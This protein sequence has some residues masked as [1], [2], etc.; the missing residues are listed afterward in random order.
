[1]V[2]T[3]SSANSSNNLFSNFSK[4]PGVKPAQIS[5]AKTQ[6]PE[7]DEF[8]SSSE[9][10]SKNVQTVDLSNVFSVNS[11]KKSNGVVAELLNEGYAQM[12]RRLLETKI[13]K[14]LEFVGITLGEND[15]L[16]FK[17]DGSGQ[18]YMQSKYSHLEDRDVEK[19]TAVIEN[20]LNESRFEDE[21]LGE[22]LLKNFSYGKGIDLEEARQDDS[23][24]ASFTFRYNKKTGRHE[25]G[26]I[27]FN[28]GR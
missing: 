28:I 12:Q 8:I 20:A 11:A 2:I 17:I 23:F 26:N 4:A 21:P 24:Y 14:E 5:K 27:G 9:S 3:N 6:E 22:A 18:I 1:M 15:Y 25:I 7:K 19:T 13:M 10:K 16:S